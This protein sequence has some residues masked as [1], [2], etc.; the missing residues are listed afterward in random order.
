MNEWNGGHRYTAARLSISIESSVKV[1]AAVRVHHLHVEC[2]FAHSQL[3][4]R[5]GDPRYVFIRARSRRQ[6]GHTAFVFRHIVR[7]YSKH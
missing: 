1:D 2:R 7:L 4:A 3:E 5:H 6:F